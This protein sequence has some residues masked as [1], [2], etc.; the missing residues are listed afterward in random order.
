MPGPE[1]SYSSSEPCALSND[2]NV[3]VLELEWAPESRG[4]GGLFKYRCLASHTWVSDSGG[5]GLRIC[6]FT[7]FPRGAD[8]CWSRGHA[9]GP[10]DVRPCYGCGRSSQERNAHAPSSQRLARSR[11]ETHRNRKRNPHDH[12]TQQKAVV[13]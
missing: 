8:G 1:A 3:E 13:T 11:L 4:R 10:A 6:I 9:P 5:Q 2:A 7:K 12:A